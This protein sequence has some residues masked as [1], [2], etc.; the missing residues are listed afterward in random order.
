MRAL[1]FTALV[2]MPFAAEANTNEFYE[3]VESVRKNPEKW[4]PVAYAVTLNRLDVVAFLLSRGEDVNAETPGKKLYE[5]LPDRD[6]DYDINWYNSIDWD[7]WFLRG[8]NPGYSPLELAAQIQN[9]EMVRFLCEHGAD[10]M[11]RHF[12]VKDKHIFNKNFRGGYKLYNQL[13]YGKWQ[14]EAHSPLTEALQTGNGE[15]IDVLI[16]AYTNPERLYQDY[17]FVQK[18]QNPVAMRSWL[19]RYQVLTSGS[20]THVSDDI[21]TLFLSTTL[22]NAIDNDD[23]ASLELLLINGL[24]VHEKAFDLA[25][26]KGT[27][28]VLDTLMLNRARLEPFDPYEKLLKHGFDEIVKTYF[29]DEAFFAC[30]QNNRDD[31]V[32]YGIDLGF[33]PNTSHLIAAVE[34]GALDVTSLFCMRGIPLDGALIA[35]VQKK[36]GPIVRLLVSFD[37]SYEELVR[38]QSLSYELH[39]YDLFDVIDQALRVRN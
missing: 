25:V 7:K 18:S 38:A 39:A 4:P 8:V 5:A 15:I 26:Q 14:F 23:S 36:Q 1:L 20:N 37:I 9:A 16:Q 24:N 22:E 34:H 29:S 21:V 19:E 31:L 28:R 12:R 30:A 27:T 13:D 2:C 10:V 32:T 33:E 3:T 35:A 6:D 17:A 11:L